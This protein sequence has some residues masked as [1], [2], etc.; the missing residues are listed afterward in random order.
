[1]CKYGRIQANALYQR[2]FPDDAAKARAFDAIAAGFYDVNFGVMPKSETELMMFSL[3]MDRA[4]A[5]GDPALHTDYS[6]SKQLG[7]SA[8]RIAALKEK[9]YLKYADS[10]NDW[11]DAFLRCA[12]QAVY[13]D[14]MIRIGIP[15]RIVYLEVN[16]ALE[17]MG[18]FPDTHLNP[19]LLTITPA[20]LLR[21]TVSISED[22]CQNEMLG[23]LRDKLKT[24]RELT[25]EFDKEDVFERIKKLGIGAIAELIDETVPICGSAI[26]A[27]ILKACKL[28][29]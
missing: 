22:A 27:T 28:D 11:K 21:F 6:L 17:S 14:G 19:K 23:V 12:A 18:C 8:S 29:R 16:Y 20:D 1:M 3:Y 13:A 15:E 2:L 7:I 9:R 5:E 10:A 25:N 24:D 26:K 4:E